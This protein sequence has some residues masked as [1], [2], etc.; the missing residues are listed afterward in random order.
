MKFSR[1]GFFTLFFV[2]PA[3]LIPGIVPFDEPLGA[4]QLGM[5]AVLL[6]PVPGHAL[7]G[8]DNHLLLAVRVLWLHFQL[9]HVA[10]A[11]LGSLSGALAFGPVHARGAQRQEQQE[12][13]G[14]QEPHAGREA[15]RE[16]VFGEGARASVRRARLFLSGARLPAPLTPAA[17]VGG[18]FGAVAARCAVRSAR[19]KFPWTGAPGG[20]QPMGLQRAAHDL[21][22]EPPQPHHRFGRQIH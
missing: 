18:S 17:P 16:Q 1:Q 7:G 6:T 3:L 15:R 22:A 8:D 14:G 9:L 11:N 5:Q 12:Q 4:L 19:W 21:A 13:R 20:L 10:V 2:D